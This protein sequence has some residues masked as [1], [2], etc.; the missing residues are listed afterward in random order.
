M[1]NSTGTALDPNLYFCYLPK[2]TAPISPA[3]TTCSPDATWM[4]TLFILN[5]VA[6]ALSLL[7]GHQAIRNL[8]PSWLHPGTWKPWSGIVASAIHVAT[9]AISTGISRSNGYESD[10]WQLMGV[11]AM[12]P[13]VSA[14]NILWVIAFREDFLWSLQDSVITESILNF[15]TVGLATQLRN[16]LDGDNFGCRVPGMSPAGASYSNLFGTLNY[17]VFAACSSAFQLALLLIKFCQGHA[18]DFYGIDSGICGLF[19]ITATG[20]LVSGWLFWHGESADV[21]MAVKVG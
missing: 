4:R 16:G 17:T 6:A 14:L 18:D 11:W 8:I 19:F 2:G 20:S 12:R 15:V 9:I 21:M 13:R 1:A 5:A 10:F 7:F 3:A